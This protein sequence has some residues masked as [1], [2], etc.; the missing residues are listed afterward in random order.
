MDAWMEDFCHGLGR[1][2]SAESMFEW[3]AEAAR[4]LGFE[5]CAYGVRRPLPLAQPRALLLNNYDPRWQQRYLSAGYL[6]TDPIVAHGERSV[7]PVVWSE[8]LFRGFP[9]MW[10][11]ARSF[12]IEVGWSQSCFDARGIGGMLSLARSHERLSPAELRAKEPGLRWL[13]NIAHVAL[14]RALLVR[15]RPPPSLTE[16]EDEI[17][18]WTADGKTAPEIAQIL[19]LSVNTVNYHIKHALPKLGA[20]TKA[21][22]VACLLTRSLH[23]PSSL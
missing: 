16:R 14:S 7:E 10:D 6:S 9:Q 8:E 3:I 5:R 12:G 19:H 11:E 2:R 22:A 17:L 4:H 20:A 13:V 18:R 1:A 23:S 21:A 15:D